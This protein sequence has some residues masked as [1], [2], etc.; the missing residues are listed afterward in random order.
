MSQ[1]SDNVEGLWGSWVQ[2][3]SVSSISLII[4]NSLRSV[5][6]TFPEFQG[7]DSSS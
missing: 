6:L 3:L 2:A 4:G 7:A 1:G 5:S